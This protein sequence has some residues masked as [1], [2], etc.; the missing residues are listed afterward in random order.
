MFTATCDFVSV[1]RC[2]YCIEVYKLQTTVLILNALK[3]FN[4]LY[5]HGRQIRRGSSSSQEGLQRQIVSDITSNW[6]L[7]LLYKFFKY[8]ASQT[9]RQSGRHVLDGT[10]QDL[11]T[12]QEFLSH[13]RSRLQYLFGNDKSVLIGVPLL[14][15]IFTFDNIGNSSLATP[16]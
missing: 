6:K 8:L 9:L 3:L 13:Q 4:L 2:I 14:L 1:R 7:A 16:P 15:F 5:S 12:F 11:Y 10:L